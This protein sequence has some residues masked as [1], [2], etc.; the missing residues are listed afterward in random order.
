MLFEVFAECVEV[1][2]GGAGERIATC[3]AV[4]RAS[5]AP[6]VPVRADINAPI[7]NSKLTHHQKGAHDQFE[8]REDFN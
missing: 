3:A 2:G 4:E 5:G 6:A 8:I 1:G 7:L